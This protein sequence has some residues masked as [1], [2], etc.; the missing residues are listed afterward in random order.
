VSRNQEFSVP[1]VGSD[2]KKVRDAFTFF[3]RIG[4]EGCFLGSKNAFF[5]RVT[6]KNKKN[7]LCL[8]ENACLAMGFE[9]NQNLGTAVA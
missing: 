6:G 3:S 1:L 8:N 2:T 9:F 5:S 7:R 4:F